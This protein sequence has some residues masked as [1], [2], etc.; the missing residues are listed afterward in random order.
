MKP[1]PKALKLA[2]LVVNRADQLR[3]GAWESRTEGKQETALARAYLALAA[4]CDQLEAV[5][6]AA[7]DSYCDLGDMALQVG[8]VIDEEDVRLYES[9]VKR[10][11]IIVNGMRAISTAKAGRP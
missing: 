10:N 11:G 1:D 9:H 4:H 6:H 3:G 5:I 2:Y 8:D 7:A